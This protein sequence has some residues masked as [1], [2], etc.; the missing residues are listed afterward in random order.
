MFGLMTPPR[1]RVGVMSMIGLLVRNIIE[2]PLTVE[3]G[4]H[5]VLVIHE[6]P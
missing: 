3:Q 5:D 6:S 1:V 2:I 4:L